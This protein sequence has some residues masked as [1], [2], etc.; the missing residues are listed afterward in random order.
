MASNSLSCI[1]SVTERPERTAATMPS[2]QAKEVEGVGHRVGVKRSEPVK[3]GG[4]CHGSGLGWQCH[5]R[6]LQPLI[7]KFGITYRSDTFFRLSCLATAWS[8]PC[9]KER[10]MVVTAALAWNANRRHP[11]V[12]AVVSWARSV[13]G[14]VAERS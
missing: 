12:D 3:D 13:S 1:T 7:C 9:L 10:V 11:I 8:I 4:V 5:H 2:W 14:K 6:R